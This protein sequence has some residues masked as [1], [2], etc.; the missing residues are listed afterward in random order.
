MQVRGM[1][2]AHRPNTK[3]L[4]AH[5]HPLIRQKEKKRAARA[6]QQ[7]SRHDAGAARVP[8]RCTRVPLA[9]RPSH[10][11]RARTHA[12]ALEPG[13]LACPLLA[14]RAQPRP[15]CC[16]AGVYAV[17]QQKCL[18]RPRSRCGTERARRA[19]AAARRRRTTAKSHTAF[20]PQQLARCAAASNRAP[21]PRRD[22]QLVLVG[23]GGVGKTTFVK[24]HQTGEF[25]KKYVGAPRP[26]RAALPSG[27][28]ARRAAR[29]RQGATPSARRGVESCPR[30]RPS[31]AREPARR[32]PSR[33]DARCGGAPAPIPHEPRRAGLQRVGHGGAGEVWRVARRVLH[34]GPVR[35]HDV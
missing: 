12:R 4:T 10:S 1:V 20:N 23:D 16:R 13:R 30:P 8:K 26:P 6:S 15:R 34:P 28:G 9:Q 35:H 29:R 7:D 24:R 33:S 27:S 2:G 21:S 18:C 22:A 17:S 3:S 32:P 31:P 5:R 19:L 11:S 14:P 25:E